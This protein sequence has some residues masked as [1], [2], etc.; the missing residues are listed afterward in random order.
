MTHA[1]VG[2]AKKRAETHVPGPF[3]TWRAAEQVETRGRVLGKRVNGQVRLGEHE[4]TGHT[5]G[6]G[7]AMPLR[8]PDRVQREL[9]HQT[10]EKALQRRDIGEARSITAERLDDPFFTSGWIHVRPALL[11]RA[12]RRAAGRA[13]LGDARQFRAAVNAELAV[14]AR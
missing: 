8:F 6:T 13:E 5:A 1:H 4:Q 11:S 7:E 2:S 3:G 12:L 9:L 14:G 10:G